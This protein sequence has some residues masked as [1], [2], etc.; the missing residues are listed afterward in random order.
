MGIAVEAMGT[1]GMER[2]VPRLDA[3]QSREA[4]AVLESCEGQQES[5]DNFLARERAWARRTFGLKGQIVRL[6]MFKSMN[7]YEQKAAAKLMAQ[8]TRARR[9]LIELAA[10]AYELDKNERPKRLADLVPAYL[11]AIPQDPVTGTNMA[12]P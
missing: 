2:V 3:K 5:A 10:R 12:Y 8:Q 4:S 9:L 6:F 1:T 11:K 7:E